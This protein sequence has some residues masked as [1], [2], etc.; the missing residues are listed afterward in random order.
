MM[1]SSE[2]TSPSAIKVGDAELAE[3]AAGAVLLDSG[4]ACVL[5]GLPGGHAAELL[6]NPDALW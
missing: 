6:D 4:R 2:K 5:W 3:D 1:F